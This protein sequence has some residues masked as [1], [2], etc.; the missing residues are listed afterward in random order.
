MSTTSHAVST[1]H[2]QLPQPVNRALKIGELGVNLTQS[3]LGNQIAATHLLSSQPSVVLWQEIFEMQQ[4]V[5]QR[6]QDQQEEWLHGMCNILGEYSE[7]KKANTLSK[8]MEQECNMFN[9]LGSLGTAQLAAWVGM[10]ENVQ[11]G[12]AWWLS[13]KQHDLL[14]EQ[15]LTPQAG[16]EEVVLDSLA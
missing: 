4:A 1:L 5:L 11:I 8:L 12:Y 15:S 14:R 9:Q 3:L 16:D 10:L 6:M 13:Q 2:N 7:L